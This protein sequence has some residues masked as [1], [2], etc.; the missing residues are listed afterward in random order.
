M[1]AALSYY[2]A[3]AGKL[4]A[5]RPGAALHERIEVSTTIVWGTRDQAIRRTVAERMRTRHCPH[6]AIRWVEGATHWLPDERPEEVARALLDGLDQPL[7]GPPTGSSDRVDRRGRS[8]CAHR[9]S[10]VPDQQRVH[11]LRDGEHTEEHVRAAAETS[12][13]SAGS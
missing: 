1:C 5:A 8:S 4:F 12:P 7:G 3:G 9:A 2:R 10:T 13:S 6:A 11:Q